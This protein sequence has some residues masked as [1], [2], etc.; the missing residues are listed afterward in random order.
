M[1]ADTR[2]FK[3]SSQSE[4]QRL[5]LGRVLPQRFQ[6]Q[7]LREQGERQFVLFVSE[8]GGDFLKESFI[9]AMT[10]DGG[11]QAGPFLTQPKFR[12]TA[13]KIAEAFLRQPFQRGLTTAGVCQWNIPRE[14]ASQDG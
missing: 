14:T 9:A 13:Q 4:K 8:R 10:N 11:L 12:G 1:G 3:K 5:R 6:G 2:R 7:P